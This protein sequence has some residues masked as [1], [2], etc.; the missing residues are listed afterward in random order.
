ML[1]Q[2]T[3]FIVIVW[4]PKTRNIVCGGG[5]VH[6]VVIRIASRSLDLGMDSNNCGWRVVAHRF[7]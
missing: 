4:C 6:L 1:K 2:P 3:M 5:G 7:L